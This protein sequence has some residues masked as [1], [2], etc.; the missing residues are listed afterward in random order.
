MQIERNQ[1]AVS[2]FCDQMLSCIWRY[3]CTMKNDRCNLTNREELVGILDLMKNEEPE[4]EKQMSEGNYPKHWSSEARA[5]SQRLCGWPSTKQ[6]L[7]K[8]VEVI[9]KEGSY[10]RAAALAIWQFELPV[11]LE[12]LSHPALDTDSNPTAQILAIALSGYNPKS[13][14]WKKTTLQLIT[15]LD[16]PYLCGIFIFL[17]GGSD[18]AS[19][20]LEVLDQDI[21]LA[22]KVAFACRFL[23]KTW[24]IKYLKQLRDLSVKKG[25]L[26]GLLVTGLSPTGDTTDIIQG[27]IDRTGDVQ[28]A[29]LLACQIPPNPIFNIWITCY[30]ELLDSWKMW[31]QR[32]H[33]DVNRRKREPINPQVFLRC[34]FC[35]GAFTNLNPNSKQ[36]INEMQACPNCYKPLPR[37]T[38]C[39]LPVQITD[40]IQEWFSWCQT[41]KHA[42][43]TEHLEAWF[44]T[45]KE[46]PANNCNCRCTS[47]KGWLQQQAEIEKE[48]GDC[49]ACSE[50]TGVCPDY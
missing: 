27:Y 12:C 1:Q 23:P 10:S 28:T 4:K 50:H 31:S 32:A 36:I 43:H 33:F 15:Q 16:D 18:M 2:L 19:A 21:A 41:C 14:L 5:F 42:G 37:C 47:H 44:K 38:I 39:L 48:G 29:A 35:S 26:E 6:E 22:D 8:E 7:E 17:C 30:R 46:C 45:H 25:K 49:V 13:E 20:Y 3:L 11:A 40:N 9:Q 34:K 24:L